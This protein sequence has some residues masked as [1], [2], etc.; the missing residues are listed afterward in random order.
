[1]AEHWL[2][3]SRMASLASLGFQL[4]EELAGALPD[5][6]YRRLPFLRLATW[7]WELEAL[8][9]QRAILGSLSRPP[10]ASGFL[11]ADEVRRLFPWLNG[12]DALGATVVCDA[13]SCA[14]AP[15]PAPLRRRG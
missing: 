3:R 11:S 6:G 14:H 4:N 9:K 12:E 5:Y 7:P 13:A 2:S 10:A 8:E 1:M 15:P